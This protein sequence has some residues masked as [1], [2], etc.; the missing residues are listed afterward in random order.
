[1]KKGY[2]FY[3]VIMVAVVAVVSGC[4]TVPKKLREEV[5]GINTKVDTLETRVE[6]VESKQGDIERIT[7]EQAQEL[8]EMKSR[9]ESV[10][11]TNVTV[12][13]RTGD[14]TKYRVKDIQTCLKNAG[15]YDGKIDGIKGRKTRKA[16]RAFQS[17]NGLKA[18]GVVG[19]KTWDAL[20]KY[21]SG[22]AN[23]EE[24]AVK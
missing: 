11:Q 7:S 21:A 4:S 19:T 24:G 10:P 17:A 5:S 1:M 6:S 3:V 9:R 14:F 12:K 23:T 2:I 13:D 8:Q 16:I 20:S 18:D 22:P 15:Y